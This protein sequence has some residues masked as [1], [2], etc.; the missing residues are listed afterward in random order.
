MREN[1]PGPPDIVFLGLGTDVNVRMV[2]ERRGAREGSLKIVTFRGDF[3]RHV[4]SSLATTT[5]PTVS[6]QKRIQKHLK[7]L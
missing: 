6:S 5:T 1:I 7:A 3:L 4:S 2:I